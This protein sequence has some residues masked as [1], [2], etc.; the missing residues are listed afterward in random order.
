MLGR[1]GERAMRLGGSGELL[2]LLVRFLV[3]SLLLLLLPSLCGAAGRGGLSRQRW[4]AVLCS[5]AAARG[6]PCLG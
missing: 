1:S 5:A 6:R 2:R 4:P 3:R